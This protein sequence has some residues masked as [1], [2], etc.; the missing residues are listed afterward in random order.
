MFDQRFILLADLLRLLR[1]GEVD[2]VQF[3]RPFQRNA[4]WGAEVWASLAREPQRPINGFVWW[5]PPPQEAPSSGRY[6]EFT[7]AKIFFVDGQQRGTAL[8]GGAGIRPACYP[9]DVWAELGGP[10]LEVGV[11]LES[12]RRLRIQ[13]MRARRHPQIRLGDLLQAAPAE[14]PQLV[15]DAGAGARTH[16]ASQLVAELTDLR[17]RL[18]DTEIP[19][20][21]LRGGA[22][23]AA[24]CYQVLNQA[25]STRVAHASEI[26][27][28]Y[29]DLA[30][31]GVRREMLDPLWRH[32]QREG[33]GAAVT[34]PVINELVQR[35][36]PPA[37]RRRTALKA[38]S[39]A[40]EE[41]ARRAVAGCTAMMDS[42]QRW[43]LCDASLLAMPAALGVLF[44]LGAH[45]REASTDDFPR[46]WLVHALATGRYNGA[47]YRA[48]GDVSAML[49]AGDY[50]EARTVLAQ[51]MLPA[52]P[53]PPLAP[54]QLH[55]RRG[56]FGAVT[57]LYAMAAASPSGLGVPDLTDPDAVFP[58]AG[59]S[60]VP[61]WRGR[62]E[63]SLGDFVLATPATAQ[64]LARTGGWG[65]EAYE[66]LRCGDQVLA[67][68][69]LPVPAGTGLGPAQLV[70]AREQDL[71]HMINGFLARTG[72]LQA[73]GPAHTARKTLGPTDTA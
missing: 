17:K 7:R 44:H 11:V 10:G 25:S 45:F 24:E 15:A 73:P 72:P 5:L 48:S 54:A 51:L 36:L 59:M 60:L 37:A 33:F 20:M 9:P 69:C 65:R 26:E 16:E 50:A 66:Q 19:V 35:L 49:R 43:G 39:A 27:T 61:L 55:G 14:I 52:G 47:P 71:L 34:F 63:A 8:A 53:P 6:R 1:D 40:V 23:D 12:A 58:E 32:A 62:L 38:G 68:H 46:R 31:P 29:L 30:R 13:P 4:Q 22:L 64:V 18:L 70:K 42:L 67:A 3:G 28:L 57:S 2:V 56:G 41:A 21:W